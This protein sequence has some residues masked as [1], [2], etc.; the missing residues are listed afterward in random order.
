MVNGLNGYGQVYSPYL[1]PQSTTSPNF[2]G[3]PG[4]YGPEG[5]DAYIGN[6][7]KHK[8]EK[9]AIGAGI[10]ATALAIGSA[11]VTHGKTGKV[12]T[13]EFITNLNPAKWLPE[14]GIKKLIEKGKSKVDELAGGG[15]NGADATERFV[16]G[17]LDQASAARIKELSNYKKLTAEQA[18]ELA[19]LK[20]K[21]NDIHLGNAE[22]KL[23]DVATKY[24]DLAKQ[25]ASAKAE[26]AAIEAKLAGK[27]A[28]AGSAEEKA[29]KTLDAKITNYEKNMTELKPM[30][31]HQA[32][33]K[34]LSK[35]RKMEGAYSAKIDS[36][37]RLID[38]H[39][40]QLAELQKD[41]AKLDPAKD[42][43]ALEALTKQMDELKQ[44]KLDLETEKKEFAKIQT[45][46]DGDIKTL[47]PKVKAAQ[48]TNQI[49]KMKK[50]ETA[51]SKEI[52]DLKA[53]DTS[54]ILPDDLKAHNELVK[55]KEA[56]LTKLQGRL[57]KIAPTP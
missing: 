51:L 12:F 4:V 39:T 21:V 3:G 16:G 36:H 45:K 49:T 32:D 47:D 19:T 8:G 18:E 23:K 20:G 57:A 41:A 13:K 54:S 28:V 11:I 35:M 38:G 31:K 27:P 42:K 50:A 40:K 2:Q 22:A 15:K 30:V 34:N 52:T 33:V 46:L 44:K 29:L 24:G 9:V 25:K 43:D 17:K 48:K 5:E 10:L 26:K 53:K 7:S 56:E 37:T 6:V 14:G 55:A 1:N